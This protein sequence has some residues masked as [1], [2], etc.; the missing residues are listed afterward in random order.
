MLHNTH[1]QMT[2]PFH[3]LES[4]H[5]ID[6]HVPMYSL[7]CAPNLYTTLNSKQVIDLKSNML[8]QVANN[9][10]NAHYG[11]ASYAEKKDRYKYKKQ[12]QKIE[13]EVEMEYQKA[14]K[15]G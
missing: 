8:R 1:A 4:T 14:Y 11:I 2:T 5:A 10:H 9:I 3:I 12:L 15:Q 6:D 13:K 7:Y